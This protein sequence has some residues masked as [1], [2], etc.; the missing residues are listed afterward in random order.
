MGLLSELAPLPVYEEV[1]DYLETLGAYRGAGF[2][3][4]GVYPVA[5]ERRG[6]R[7]IEVDCVMVRE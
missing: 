2:F 4:S 3:L 1:E 6:L 5:R 7:L